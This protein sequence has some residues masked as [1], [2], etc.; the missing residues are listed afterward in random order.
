VGESRTM[1]RAPRGAKRCVA[2]TT[3]AAET[4]SMVSAPSR[5][6]TTTSVPTRPGGTA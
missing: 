6:R 3:P 2:T 1:R 5:H 4:M